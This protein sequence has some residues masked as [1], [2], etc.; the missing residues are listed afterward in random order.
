[1]KMFNVLIVLLFLSN[2][3][4]SQQLISGKYNSGLRLAYD[5]SKNLIT[6]HF[7]EYTGWDHETKNPRFSCIFYIEGMIKN[8]SADIHTYFQLNKKDDLI[9]GK[10]KLSP[11]KQ[12]TLKLAQDH[13][14][15]WNVQPFM[16]EPIYFSLETKENWIQ[17]R[18]V[19]AQKIFFFSDKDLNKKQKSYLLQGD[20]VYIEKIDDNWAYCT[21][22]G[23]KKTIK[24]WIPLKALNTF[25]N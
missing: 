24:G 25:S 15:C 21:Y 17:I 1:M 16:Y 7:E 22:Y 9:D 12:I 10:L 14:G 5:S 8:D 3:G 2:I 19:T 20:I 6:G 4:I 23:K 11:D 13:G 18:Y